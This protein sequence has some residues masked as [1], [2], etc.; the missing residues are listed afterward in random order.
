MTACTLAIRT[1]ILFVD[2]NDI[3]LVDAVKNDICLRARLSMRTILGE[4]VFHIFQ[5][6]T[7]SAVKS[8]ISSTSASGNIE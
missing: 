4:I 5:D 6:D 1:L 2:G 8:D 7:G 3:G